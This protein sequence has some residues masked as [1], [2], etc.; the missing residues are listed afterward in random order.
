MYY[1]AR[2]FEKGWVGQW[3]ALVCIYILDTLH[4]DKSNSYFMTFI[5]DSVT[6]KF[7]RSSGPGGQNVNKCK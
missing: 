1:C 2:I 5:K 7:A 6:V 4:F 3:G